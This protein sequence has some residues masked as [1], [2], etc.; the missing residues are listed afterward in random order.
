[1]ET[2]IVGRN[3]KEARLYL[4]LTKAQVSKILKISLSR[5]VALEENLEY[6]TNLE[7]T[8]FSKL[9]GVK[10][11]DLLTKHNFDLTK[12]E[13]AIAELLRFKEWIK[14]EQRR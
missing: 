11:K 3:L 5:V 8:M 13:K 2:N 10:I 9:Y 1:M 4:G 14:N 12:D 6:P 7:L